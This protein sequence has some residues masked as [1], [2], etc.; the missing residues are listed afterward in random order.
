MPAD[1]VQAVALAAA[2]SSNLMEVH[3]LDTIEGTHGPAVKVTNRNNTNSHYDQEKLRKQQQSAPNRRKDGSTRAWYPPR[4]NGES[5]LEILEES[6]RLREVAEKTGF[7]EQYI[8]N[9]IERYGIIKPEKSGAFG[10]RPTYQFLPEHIEAIL[11]VKRLSEGGKPIREIAELMQNDAEYREVAKR[12]S[13]SLLDLLSAS[14][15]DEEYWHEMIWTLS[16]LPTLNPEERKVLMLVEAEQ[17]DLAH[18]AVDLGFSSERDAK[19]AL[20]DA[21]TKVGAAI[22]YLLRLST[23]K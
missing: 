2:M 12:F 3:Q 23:E 9:L 19:T 8:L 17:R 5:A 18:V 20:D 14:S 11:R 15:P 4:S 13:A 21:R 6:L 7:S 16:R 1:K 10:T 22:L